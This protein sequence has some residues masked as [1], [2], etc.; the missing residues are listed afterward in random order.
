MAE[1]LDYFFN[2]LPE[3]ISV[4]GCVV[5]DVSPFGKKETFYKKIKKTLYI[6]GVLFTFHYG[7]K[8]ICNRLNKNKKVSKVLDKHNIPVIK[9]KE[10]IN[11][12]RSLKILESYGPD[13]L[14]SIAGNEIFRN[15]LINLAPKGCLNLH[16]ALLPK[17]RGLMPSFWVLKNNETE[18]GVAVFFGDQGIDSGP[19]LVQKHMP[20]PREMSQSEL[21]WKSKKL[22]MDA[23]IDAVKLIQYDNYTLIPNPD[24]EKT[25]YSFP[26]RQDIKNFY[27]QGKKFY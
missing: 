3:N 8:F 15:P 1:I 27:K 17:Y 7:F 22:G 21:I 12:E 13:L 9:L 19:I 11:S 26:T 4:V 14:I 6:F 10:S 25:Y 24:R 23:V 20:I 18:T 5:A 2:K 16:T